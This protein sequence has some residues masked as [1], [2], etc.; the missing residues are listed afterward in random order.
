ML[1][2]IKSILL[3]PS[4]VWER[5]VSQ[6]CMPNSS[7]SIGGFKITAPPLWLAVVLPL[8]YFAAAVAFH[9][10]LWRQYPD[11]GLECVRR[12][13][14]VAQ[15][16]LNLAGSARPRRWP[17]TTRRTSSPGRRSS[18]SASSPAN[19]VE[20]LLVAV[21]SSAN[22]GAP[23]GRRHLAAGK[24]CA[25]VPAGAERECGRGRRLARSRLWR[26][27]SRP[28]GRPGICPTSAAC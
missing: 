11:L 5:T 14:L 26:A 12:D 28:D 7:I 6:C 24:T 10:R 19:V 23:A 22:G 1:K 9:V 17:P 8:V 4:G 16:T 15:Q 3:N 18:G 21:L 13:G 25:R 20:I 2:I 27:V